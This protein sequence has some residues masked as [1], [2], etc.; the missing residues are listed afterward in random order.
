MRRGAEIL[1]GELPDAFG[2]AVLRLLADGELRARIAAQGRVLVQTRFAWARI[3]DG[4]LE[5]YR[6]LVDGAALASAHA[7]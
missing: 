4:L 2:D 7:G 6:D 1:V 3:A 5:T